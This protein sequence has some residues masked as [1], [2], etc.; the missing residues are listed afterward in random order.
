LQQNGGSNWVCDEEDEKRA[1]F[2]KLEQEKADLDYCIEM[3]KLQSN[4]MKKIEDEDEKL[5]M[6][7]IR[8]SEQ[9]FQQEQQQSTFNADLEEAKKISK[10]EEDLKKQA[11]QTN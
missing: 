11:Q 10:I 2:E 5:L 9:A 7:A 3:S 4:D 8:L 1:L 6:E